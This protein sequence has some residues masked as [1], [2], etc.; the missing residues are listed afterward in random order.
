MVALVSPVVL[1]ST[2]VLFAV[3]V[4]GWHHRFDAVP[5]IRASAAVAVGA[6]FVVYSVASVAELLEQPVESV[7]VVAGALLLVAASRHLL[8]RISA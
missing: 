2:L 5:P 7:A 6:F 8:H 3:F 4:V 1:G